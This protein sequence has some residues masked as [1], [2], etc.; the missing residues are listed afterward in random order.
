MSGIIFIHDWIASIWAFGARFASP[1]L[2][3]ET[4]FA[5]FSSNW[6]DSSSI[7]SISSAAG[8]ACTCTPKPMATPDSTAGSAFCAPDAAASNVVDA[9]VWRRIWAASSC[10]A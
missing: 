4:S 2:R 1:S 8:S 3:S 9:I 5:S 7:E 6:N 10:M